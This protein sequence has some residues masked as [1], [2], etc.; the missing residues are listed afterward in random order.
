MEITRAELEAMF[1]DGVDFMIVPESVAR[2]FYIDPAEGMTGLFSVC[3][4]TTHLEV[5]RDGVWAGMSTVSHRVFLYM[6]DGGK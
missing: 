2:E 6:P 3:E 1:P 4:H 5:I